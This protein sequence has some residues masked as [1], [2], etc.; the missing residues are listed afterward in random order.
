MRSY[1][2]TS[3]F[4]R[5]SLRI[6]FLKNFPKSVQDQSRARKARVF[7]VQILDLAKKCGVCETH[8]LR[9]LSVLIRH[10]DEGQ[11]WRSAHRFKVP[12][13]VFSTATVAHNVHRLRV[14]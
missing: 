3:R 12:P 1:N 5:A 14:N 13:V 10:Q 7:G 2:E 8:L 11:R 4:G 9:T 6:R